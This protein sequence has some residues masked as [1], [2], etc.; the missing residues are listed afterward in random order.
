MR[1]ICED[2]SER[3]RTVPMI[4]WLV[5][6]FIGL[7]IYLLVDWLNSKCIV[8]QRLI[9]FSSLCYVWK[10]VLGYLLGIDSV[11]ILFLL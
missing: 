7:F 2:K 6:W 1:A 10:K 9:A 3:C 5:D 8:Y 11:L 4:G